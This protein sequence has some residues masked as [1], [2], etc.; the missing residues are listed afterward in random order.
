MN[1][2]KP[3]GMITSQNNYDSIERLIYMEGLRIKTIDV[4]P[5][6][7]L[8]LIILNTNT[9]LQQKISSYPLLQSATK[10]QLL[11][12]EIQANGTGIYWYTLDEDLS[13]KGFLTDTLK[14]F[15]GNTQTASAA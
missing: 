11:Q 12:Y 15:V 13:L 1:N 9:V 4:H 6:L 10:E 7:D 3:N 8:L 2:L 5:E 14:R